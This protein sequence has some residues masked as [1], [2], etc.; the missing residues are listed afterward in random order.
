MLWQDPA[1]DSRNVAKM[2]KMHYVSVQKSKTKY[3]NW[4]NSY[5]TCILNVNFWWIFSVKICVGLDS[6]KCATNN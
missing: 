3:Q 6:P 5:K 1:D 2:I 4:K